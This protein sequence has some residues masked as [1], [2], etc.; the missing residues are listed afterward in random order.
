[1]ELR[2]TISSNLARLPFLLP[3]PSS[4]SRARYCSRWQS[5]FS[6]CHVSNRLQDTLTAT[7]YLPTY[8]GAGPRFFPGEVSGDHRR[9]SSLL[10][11]TLRCYLPPPPPFISGGTG[12]DCVSAPLSLA[13]EIR[14][15]A[16]N[17]RVG[18]R[19]QTTRNASLLRCRYNSQAYY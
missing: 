5:S 2:N 6:G 16:S 3:P 11:R 13:L 17:F 8:L 12:R 15:I 7:P 9:R 4:T 18:R 14:A 1:M 19:L 10:L